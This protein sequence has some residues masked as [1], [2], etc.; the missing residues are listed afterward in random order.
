MKLI[1]SIVLSFILFSILYINLDGSQTEPQAEQVEANSNPSVE[2][3]QTDS[4]KNQPVEQT[5]KITKQDL[6]IRVKQLFPNELASARLEEFTFD[7]KD[8]KKNK[9]MLHYREN[10]EQYIPPDL[11]GTFVFY[12]KELT[13]IAAS[14]GGDTATKENSFPP[15]VDLEESREIAEEFL[16]QIYDMSD[17]GIKYSYH[18][19]FQRPITEIL[20]TEYEFYKMKDGIRISD[21]GGWILVQGD[22]RIRSYNYYNQPYENYYS[23]L[24]DHTF[25]S[26]S[27]MLTEDDIKEQLKNELN[28]QLKYKSEWNSP[29]SKDISL[30]YVV[31]PSISKIRATDGT[32]LIDNDFMNIS[33]VNTIS[34]Y[35]P[36]LQSNDPST[37]DFNKNH[38]EQHAL[39]L[40]EQILKIKS[41]EINIEK[42][43]E[44]G[45]IE[46]NLKYF[47]SFQ[48]NDNISNLNIDGN[49]GDVYYLKVPEPLPITTNESSESTLNEARESAINYIHQLSPSIAK[50]IVW[51]EH[52]EDY[53][54][55]ND[56]YTF[57]FHR[58]INGVPYEG[59]E[60]SIGISKQNG[61][62][63]EYIMILDPM[64][65]F[66][67]ADIVISE[68]EALTAYLNGMSLDLYYDHKYSDYYDDLEKVHYNLIYELNFKVYNINAATGEISPT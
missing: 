17:Y 2:V 42:I 14:F 54:T 55:T 29:E 27:K 25:D 12:G 51:R 19:D 1:L 10:G 32:Y 45:Q 47:L 18:Q 53:S 52:P 28:V 50:Q 39:N 44:S 11:R 24:Q 8:P 61:E 38:I 36:I 59:D 15:K 66:P 67:S 16:R 9:Y 62:L 30:A 7:G 58:L 31:E 63:I 41:S 26:T 33:E 21:Q 6:V 46:K 37:F 4:S 57:Q 22:G 34:A 49:S 56:S 3:D 20:Q 68:E 43:E 35:H 13:L 65:Q 23:S 60:I 40:L 64:D 48:V 5:A